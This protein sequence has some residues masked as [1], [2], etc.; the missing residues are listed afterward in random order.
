MLEVLN[1]IKKNQ[2]EAKKIIND[3]SI[4]AEKIKQGL[5]HIINNK[6]LC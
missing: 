5:L 1:I 3:A 4:D 2:M 6:L